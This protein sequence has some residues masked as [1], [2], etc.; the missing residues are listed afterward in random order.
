MIADVPVTTIMPPFDPRANCV[1]SSSMSSA[2]RVPIG[3]SST[4]SDGA[5]D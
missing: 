3:L 2:L 1:T 5:M 4:P